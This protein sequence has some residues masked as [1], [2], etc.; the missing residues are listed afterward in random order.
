MVFSGG[1]FSIEVLVF[2]R[3]Y[4]ASRALIKALPAGERALDAK[5]QCVLCRYDMTGIDAPICPECGAD[6]DELGGVERYFRLAPAP[7]EGRLIQNFG[8]VLGA[9]VLLMLV[10]SFIAVLIYEAFQPA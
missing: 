6:L 9:G 10:L 2:D 5:G 8:A 1:Q 7:G 3:D 4:E